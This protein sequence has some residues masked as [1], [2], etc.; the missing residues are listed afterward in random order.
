MPPPNSSIHHHP[1]QLAEWPWRQ[2]TSEI[3]T[4]DS[5]GIISNDGVVEETERKGNVNFSTL[6]STASSQNATLFHHFHHQHPHNND[7]IM[8]AHFFHHQR[9]F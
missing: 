2:L 6:D 8:G 9:V 3:D 4:A 7:S 1:P 5:F